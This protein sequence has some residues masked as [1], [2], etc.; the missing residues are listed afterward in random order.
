VEAEYTYF[1]L[2]VLVTALLVRVMWRMFHAAR[3]TIKQLNYETRR[4]QLQ[5]ERILREKDFQAKALK[6]G[7]RKIDGKPPSVQ[8]DS[9]ERRAK[10]DFHIDEAAHEVFDQATDVRGMDVRVPWGWPAPKGHPRVAPGSTRRSR[11]TGFKDTVARL[12]QPKQV[13]DENYL[14]RRQWSLRHLVEDRYGRVGFA[15]MGLMSDIEWS[16]PQLPAELIE[17]RKNDQMLAWK[18]TQETEIQELKG[19]RLVADNTKPTKSHKKAS[20]G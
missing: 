3:K 13:I 18:S 17:E 7:T 15:Q 1:A 6:R 10:R 20:G 12:F 11:P 9:S 8:W 2:F 19:I 16:K 4:D 5:H 14:A